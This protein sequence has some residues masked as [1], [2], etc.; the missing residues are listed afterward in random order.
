MFDNDQE[1]K[2]TIKILKG[3][4]LAYVSLAVN[5]IAGIVY[6]PWMIRQIGQSN[7]GLYTLATS[8][9]SILT[10]DF[11][12][13][14][15][16]TR[17]SALYRAKQ[18]KQGLKEFVALVY[19]LYFFIDLVFCL[20]S[21]V[22]FLFL[23]KVYA[24][25]TPD[26]MEIFRV[27]YIIVVSYNLISIPFTNLNGIIS[28]YESF[29]V[30]KGCDLLSRVLS[31][32]FVIIAL[33]SGLG[34]YALVL[35]NV[36]C[37]LITIL[38]KWYYVCSVLYV[39]PKWG[40]VN[41]ALL[42][43]VFSFSMWSMVETLSGAIGNNLMPSVVAAYSGAKEVAVF[44]TSN[45]IKGY[46]YLLLNAIDGLF[47]PKVMRVQNDADGNAHLESLAFRVGKFIFI[48]SGLIFV[49]FFLVGEEFFLLW[50]GADYKSAYPCTCFLLVGELALSPFHIFSTA[51]TAKGIVKPRA[52]LHFSAV[53]EM[54]LIGAILVPE[55]GALGAGMAVAISCL[56]RGIGNLVIYKI[57]LD[58]SI[59][60]FIRKIYLRAIP[61]IG[62]TIIIS[63]LFH[64]ALPLPMSW[65]GLFVKAAIICAMFF[66]VTICFY[67]ECDEKRQFLTLIKKTVFRG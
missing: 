35:S 36:F 51:M 20:V 18:D 29:T 23:D 9:I 13:G 66:V 25:L 6:T 56:S 19:K 1:Q 10:V 12:I 64:A 46:A 48:L 38:I 67:L 39:R 47:L 55:L 22:L 34:L 11:G 4:V 28:A 44:G 8:L 27:I 30:L 57:H 49:G 62:L 3:S 26:E 61:Y 7:Y 5:I 41:T 54:F 17:F 24:Q 14:A 50:M 43:V 59:K 60:L 53:L 32:L 2:S 40:K 52:I 31:I 37:G 16:L 21:A 42:R 58:I 45:T 63:F 15:A 33:A 65:S